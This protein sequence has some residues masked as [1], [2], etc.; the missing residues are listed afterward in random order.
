MLFQFPD[1]LADPAC[2]LVPDRAHL[3]DGFWSERLEALK[4]EAERKEK[5]THG[6]DS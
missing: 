4:R 5:S 2:D 3:L 6:R 1:K